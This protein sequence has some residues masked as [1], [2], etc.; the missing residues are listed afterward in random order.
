M[1]VII[2]TLQS[3]EQFSKSES[4]E[5][6]NREVFC[7]ALSLLPYPGRLSASFHPSS[8]GTPPSKAPGVLSPLWWQASPNSS[9]LSLTHPHS[10]WNNLWVSALPPRPTSVPTKC[11]MSLSSRERQI[12]RRE[13]EETGKEITHLVSAS[14]VEG[15]LL[16]AYVS[17]RV[18]P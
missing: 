4:L 12:R 18:E 2:I 10:G 9:L 5:V 3:K 17:W 1:T 8:T 14:C 6:Q 16:K 15:S 11:F 13:K 7:F